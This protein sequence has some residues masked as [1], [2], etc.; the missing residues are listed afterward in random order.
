[1]AEAVIVAG[2]R[3]PIGKLSGALAGF[4]AMDLG[5]FAI[6]EALSRAGRLARSGRLRAHGPG[7]SGRP[8]PDH[9][10]P[11]RGQGRDPDVR[12]G[13][14]H[15]Q[16]LPVGTQHDLPGRP[17]DPRRRGRHRRGRRHGVDDP[18][19]LPPAGRPCGLPHRRRGARRL[20]DV[21]RPHRRLRPHRHGTVDRAAQ[22]E[23]RHLPGAPG[24]LLGR[25]P[26]EGRRR[27]QGRPAGRGDR[28][29]A[30]SPAQGR[31]AAGR[32]RRGRAAGHHG[33]VARR[34]QARLH[35][36]RHHHRRQRL[37]DLRRRPRPSS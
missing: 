6:A 1:M 33:R 9:G 20:H 37:A 27:G 23:D 25:Q 13:Q 10:P 29:G 30:G 14:H 31:P 26:R 12:S 2:A 4:T 32:H 28:P 7:D 11:G 21:R 34:P 36:G 22:P 16:G 8:G 19:A 5:G 18:G 35:Q 3:T 17:D 24:R 15:Q